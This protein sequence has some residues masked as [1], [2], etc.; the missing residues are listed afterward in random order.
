MFC[1]QLHPDCKSSCCALCPGCKNFAVLRAYHGSEIKFVFDVKETAAAWPGWLLSGFCLP[2][3]MRCLHQPA[4]YTLPSSKTKALSW[5]DGK[6]NSNN[7]SSPRSDDEYFP[8]LSVIT[9]FIIF[10]HFPELMLTEQS[11]EGQHSGCLCKLNCHIKLHRKK[12]G[13]LWTY[14][15]LSDTLLWLWGLFNSP[16]PQMDILYFQINAFWQQLQP[17]PTCILSA[18]ST[19]SRSR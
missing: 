3:R 10:S 5:G 18:G 11:G 13:N 16:V 1:S 8:K 6:W 2:W 17:S 12:D 15:R 19:C 4:R 9:V 7:G 14:S